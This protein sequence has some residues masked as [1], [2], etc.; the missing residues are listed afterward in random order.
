M[1]KLLMGIVLL[2]LTTLAIAKDID[3]NKSKGTEQ[4][5]IVSLIPS[6]ADMDVNQN[7]TIK[8]VFEVELDTNHI[9]KNNIKL[10]KL[11]DK[12]KKIKGEIAYLSGEKAVTFKPEQDLEAGVYEVEIKSLKAIKEEK[13]KKIKEIKYRFYIPEVVNGYKLP[14]NPNSKIND[15]TLQ[16]VD[17][18]DNGVRDDVERKIVYKYPKKLHRILLMDGAKAF[19]K[20][21]IEPMDDAKDIEKDISRV[22]D[23]MIYLRRIDS[24]IKSYNFEFIDYLEYMTFDNPDRVRRYLDYNLALS[25]GNYASYPSDWERASCSPEVVDALEEMGL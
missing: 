10:K 13:H 16:G 18:N 24:E 9:K 2:L 25:G 17:V 15:A 21:T 3:I 20:I 11:S 6:V 23:C 19:Q 7:V 5:V 4:S 1:K 8:A 12:K 14:P 22:G